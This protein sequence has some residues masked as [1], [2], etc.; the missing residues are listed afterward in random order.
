MQLQL[1]RD[2]DVAG[3]SRIGKLGL[4]AEDAEGLADGVDVPI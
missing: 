1:D 4:R 3:R 2:L